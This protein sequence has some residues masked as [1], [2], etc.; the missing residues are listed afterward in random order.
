MS[1]FL[2]K[3]RKKY[4][5]IHINKDTNNK[6]TIDIEITNPNEKLIENMEATCTVIIEKAEN[7]VAL[8]VEAIQKDEE[9]K[10]YVDVV[11]SDSTTMPVYIKTGISDDYYVEITSGLNVGERVQIVKSSTTVVNEKTK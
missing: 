11:Q 8:P 1:R 5:F 9:N 4:Y 6:S 10:T 3:K 2:L 7:V